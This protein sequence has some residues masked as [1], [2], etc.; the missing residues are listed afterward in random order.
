[1]PT[2]LIMPSFQNRE[3][4]FRGIALFLTIFYLTCLTNIVI[5]Q[6]KKINIYYWSEENIADLGTRG[7]MPEMV[8]EYSDWQRRHN[9]DNNSIKT[10]LEANIIVIELLD[11]EL[12]PSDFVQYHVQ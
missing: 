11:I 8:S 7:S 2:M 9:N 3:N 6:F 12:S 10:L 4:I 1:M 5:K